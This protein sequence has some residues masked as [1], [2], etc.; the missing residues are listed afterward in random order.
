[1]N[2][3]PEKLKESRSMVTNKKLRAIFKG[4][5]LRYLS[6]AFLIFLGVL[7][8]IA[9]MLAV[10]RG[11]FGE[12]GAITSAEEI[13]ISGEW[14]LMHGDSMEFSEIM[15]DD[16]AWGIVNIP[17]NTADAAGNPNAIQWLRKRVFISSKELGVY[18]AISL[19]TIHA[20]D[21][22][23]FNGVLIGSTGSMT[24]EWDINYDKA[25]I[26]S[27]PLD[28]VVQDGWNVVAVRTRS[29][30]PDIAGIY[31]GTLAIGNQIG[32]NNRIIM[33]DIPL[34]IVIFVLL[35]S[36]IIFIFLSIV[37]S[38]RESEYILLSA[39]ILQMAIFVFLTTQLRFNIS[40]GFILDKTIKFSVLAMLLP[41]CMRFIYIILLLKETEGLVGKISKWMDVLTRWIFLY[42]L[43]YIIA[44][45]IIGNIRIWSALDAA[46]NDSVILVFA[47]ATL[48]IIIYMVIKGSRE[49]LLLLGGLIVFAATVVHDI[50]VPEQSVNFTVNY[51]SFGALSLVMSMNLIVAFRFHKIT[52]SLGKTNVEIEKHSR[53]LE[54][55]VREKTKSLI[56]A[57][58]KLEDNNKE[59]LGLNEQLKDTQAKLEKIAS[60]DSLTGLYNR[61]EIDKRIRYEVNTM[62]RYGKCSFDGFSILYIDMDNFKYINDTFGHQAGDLVLVRFA[63]I[64]KSVTRATDIVARYGGDEFIVLMPNTDYEGAKGL[65]ERIVKKLE[66]AD[67]FK[68]YLEEINKQPVTIDEKYA[69]S[70]S[71]GIAVY[72]EGESID[73]MIRRADKAL[74]AMKGLK[75]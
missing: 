13:S 48:V 18:N 69:L 70:G 15:F 49:A 17:A 73:E 39:F 56:E 43:I 46:V 20:A 52:F 37:R 61:F 34:V 57:N 9:V 30:F 23:Y 42:P 38:S 62:K 10:F 35:F 5:A 68:C 65:A 71:Y 11:T 50:A 75:R 55:Q 51:S 54:Q 64:L 24:D 19:G 27:L 47:A 67:S 72:T 63:E 6:I 1:M 25:R 32:F 21:E 29:I 53:E 33:R 66:E 44:N 45:L 26:Y 74:Y 40:L 22:V 2:T 16:S 41:V 14:K 58:S 3:N 31:K 36:V 8:G 59:L 12:S 60:T 7:T 4:T 28:S